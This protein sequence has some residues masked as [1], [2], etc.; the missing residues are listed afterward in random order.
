[1]ATSR[2]RHFVDALHR[3]ED[4]RQLD[5]LL[6]IFADDAQLNNP[7][8][9]SPLRG[10]S[11]VREFWQVYRDTFGSIHSDFHHV[12]EDDEST[13]L[14]WTSEGTSPG[15][16]QVRYHGVTVLEWEGEQVKK[17]RAYFDPSALGDQVRSER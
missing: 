1:M 8:V 4:E 12:L 17:F 15:G 10:E 9:E 3:L 14:E 2:S 5:P 7:T 13:M 16:E 11:G 6:S